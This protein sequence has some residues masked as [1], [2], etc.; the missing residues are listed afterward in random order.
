VFNFAHRNGMV[1]Q[2]KVFCLVCE[3]K[4][5]IFKLLE[6]KTVISALNLGRQNS[7]QLI[8]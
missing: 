5:E 8:N 2:K 6:E 4:D 7:A 1:V 3:L